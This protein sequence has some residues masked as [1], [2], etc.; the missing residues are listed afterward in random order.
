VVERVLVDVHGIVLAHRHLEDL[1][2]AGIVDQ[3]G[4]RLGRRI[5]DQP[6]VDAV[7]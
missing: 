4:Q 5:P 6:H 2:P 7:G 3:H 1:E